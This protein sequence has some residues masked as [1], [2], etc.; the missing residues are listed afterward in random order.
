[1]IPQVQRGQLDPASYDPVGNDVNLLF[2]ND[3]PAAV[4]FPAD[5][6]ARRVIR[7]Y[8]D[9]AT[10]EA[11]EFTM[12]KPPMTTA[13]LTQLVSGESWTCRLGF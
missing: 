2:T 13:K 12:T 8:T 4:A 11:L 6:I 9:T 7:V 10:G 5:A 1:M 3:G